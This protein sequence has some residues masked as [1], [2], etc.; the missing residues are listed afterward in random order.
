MNLPL[1]ITSGD[2]AGES[3]A[4][5]GL[6]G[7]ILVWHDVLYDGL[8]K[9]GWPDAATLEARAAMLEATTGGGLVRARILNGLRRQYQGL[10]EAAPARP[11]VLW[12]DACLFD[13]AMLAHILAC[14]RVERARDVALLCIDAFPGIE[15]YH[16]LGQLRPDQL[17]SCFARRRPVTAAQFDFAVDVDRV[18]AEQDLD[19]L[20]RMSRMAASP[21]PWMP[22]A[23]ARWI[24]EQ[25]DPA[26]G[27]G[28][29]A[30]LALD[31]IRSGCA[32]PA[33]IFAA[34]AAADRPPQYWGDTRLW[35]KINDLAERIPPLVRI[36]G[37][38]PRLPQWES[39]YP[40]D[41]FRIVP[42]AA[43]E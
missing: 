26:T 35:W 14:L 39:A 7:D 41:A 42:V 1:H 32:T 13:M 16:G 15:P 20:S 31:A 27:L 36:D 6:P 21:L 10:A 25:P 29:L 34:V 4:Q 9:P 5:T 30:T 11:I 24:A 2:C 17:A 23:A 22:D 8:R 18:F 37:P 28:R 38:A 40:L 33:A 19:A 3:L 12:F 43:P